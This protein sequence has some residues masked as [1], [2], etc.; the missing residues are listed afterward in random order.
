MTIS[1]PILMLHEVSARPDPRYRKY[2][3]TPAELGERLDWL[4]ARGYQSA[5][6][7]DVLAAW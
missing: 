5:G 3:L 4:R 7:D 2:T 6:M 1:L